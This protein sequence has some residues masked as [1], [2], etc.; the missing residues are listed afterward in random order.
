M[1]TKSFTDSIKFNQKSADSLI[2]ALNK[3]R[4]P[5]KIET[6]VEVIRDV[7]ILDKIINKRKVE[8]C[9]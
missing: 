3:D 7:S 8:E 6:N 4:K 2:K 9:R 1:A 5:V